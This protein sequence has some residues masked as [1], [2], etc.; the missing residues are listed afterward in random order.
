MIIPQ[1][2]G[3]LFGKVTRVN[4]SPFAKKRISSV[5][6]LRRFSRTPIA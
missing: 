5:V 1:L 2:P 3:N 6:P 4:G